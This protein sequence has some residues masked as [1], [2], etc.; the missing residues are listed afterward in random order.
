MINVLHQMFKCLDVRMFPAQ[1]PNLPWLEPQMINVLQRVF[2]S[3]NVRV[4]HSQLPNLPRS[5]L[6]V[7]NWCQDCQEDCCK[8]WAFFARSLGCKCWFWLRYQRST[9]TSKELSSSIFQSLSICEWVR[10]WC[11]LTRSPL[12]PIH[13]GINAL[14][15][16]MIN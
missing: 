9:H 2:R 10:H 13:K 1:Q 12:F 8:W 6:Q 14:F 11:H 15:W 7:I 3:S 5:G 16:P 4:F